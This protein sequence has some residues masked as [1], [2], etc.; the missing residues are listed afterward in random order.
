M[1]IPNDS[2]YHQCRVN[3]I[4]SGACHTHATLP[5]RLVL[6][7]LLPMLH[8]ELRPLWSLMIYSILAGRSNSPSLLLATHSQTSKGSNR[9]PSFLNMK[10]A[11]LHACLCTLDRRKRPRVL[12]GLP[13]WSRILGTQDVRYA[14]PSASERGKQRPADER[15]LTRFKSCIKRKVG[16]GVGWPSII[17]RR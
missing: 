10:L 17:N 4:K 11:D 13:V 12:M 9:E 15:I 16:L 7:S 2:I 14:Q 8:G 5:L 1:H 6:V 3:S